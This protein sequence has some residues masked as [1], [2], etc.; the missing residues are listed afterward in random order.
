MLASFKLCEKKEHANLR[1]KAPKLDE[2]HLD[3]GKSQ[4][5][6]TKALLPV[7]YKHVTL[8]INGHLEVSIYE[9]LIDRILWL[10]RC[11]YL[12]RNISKT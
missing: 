8:N 12:H 1:A 4:Y 11:A 3:S 10:D 7:I 5:N 6:P 9:R 2:W